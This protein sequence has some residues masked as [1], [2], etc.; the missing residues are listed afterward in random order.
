MLHHYQAAVISAILLRNED[1]GRASN[2]NNVTLTNTWVSWQHATQPQNSQE[3]QFQRPVE[4]YAMS[5]MRSQGKALQVHTEYV[6]Y[7]YYA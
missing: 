3:I 7:D 2:G 1:N 5:K 4:I 6:L